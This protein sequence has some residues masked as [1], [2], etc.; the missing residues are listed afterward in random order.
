VQKYHPHGK[1]AGQGDSQFARYAA[2]KILWN[3]GHYSRA[4]TAGAIGIYSAAMRQTFQRHQAAF[5][6]FMRG[7]MAEPHDEAGAAGIVIGMAE[8]EVSIHPL[9]LSWMSKKVK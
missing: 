7:G 5:H 9:L 3:V 1:R 8:C 4:V 2:K 6:N